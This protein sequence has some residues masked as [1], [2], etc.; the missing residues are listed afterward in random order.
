MEK[1]APGSE[2][3]SAVGSAP[4]RSRHH[5]NRVQSQLYRSDEARQGVLELE[6]TLLGDNLTMKRGEVAD[7]AGMPLLTARK[8]WRSLGLPN[9]KDDDTFF[10]HADS[11]ALEAVNS[12]VSKGKLTEE[13]ALSITRSVGQMM[14]RMVVW[15]VEALVEDMVI[16]GGL[17]DTEA[18]GELLNLLPRLIG[19]LE[20]ITVYGYRRMLNSAILRLALRDEGDGTDLADSDLPLARGVGFVDLVSYTSLSRE[21][22]ERNLARLVKNFEQ[23]CAEVI[24]V[25]GGR[26]IKTVGDEVMYLVESPEDGARIALTLSKL[27]SEDPRLPEARV[28]F[29]WGRVLPRLGD[30]YGPTV[31]LASRLV[32]L[33][34][35]GVVLTDASTAEALEHDRRFVLIPQGVRNVRGFGNV[36][37]VA[38]TPGIGNE[39]EIDFE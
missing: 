4:D 12:L 38:I 5:H 11:K 8:I 32:A 36:R 35:P 34:E 28:S 7:E 14:D 31:N 1:S 26:I 17:T 39:L 23:R 6:R 15:Q 37:P 18:R 13:A 27:I 25:G 19:D 33:T 2:T 30:I 10:T 29:V 24:A 3:A 21:M 20:D 16:N 22:N 9:S